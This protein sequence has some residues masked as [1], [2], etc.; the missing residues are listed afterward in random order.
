MHTVFNPETGRF[1]SLPSPS[2]AFAVARA[3]RMVGR[4]MS[5]RMACWHALGA[6]VSPDAYDE[7]AARVGRVLTS[8]RRAPNARYES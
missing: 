1:E 7:V 2:L 6:S 3:V 8:P 4:G 5:E